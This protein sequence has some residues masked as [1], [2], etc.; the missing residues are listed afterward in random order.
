[1]VKIRMKHAGG[2]HI[3]SVNLSQSSYHKWLVKKRETFKVETI[4]GLW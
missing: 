1:M 3:G 4:I 2:I